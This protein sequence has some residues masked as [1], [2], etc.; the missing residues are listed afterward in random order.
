MVQGEAM[1]KIQLDSMKKKKLPL[2]PLFLGGFLAGLLIPN[3]SYRFLWKQKAF[4]AVYLLELFGNSSFSGTDYLLQILQVRGSKMVLLMLCGFT[5]FGVPV[6]VLTGISVGILLGAF[7]AMSILEFGLAGGAVGI[8][9]LFPQYLI[10]FPVLFAVLE[11]AYEESLKMWKNHG[12]FPTKV[13]VYL[14][15]SLL[16]LAFYAVGMLLEC[17]VNPWIMEKILGILNLF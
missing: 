16:Y 2:F 4:E 5:V 3:L 6:A 14:V 9:F 8:A 1:K 7:L 13:S 17:F 15:H 12:I 11:M 10:Y